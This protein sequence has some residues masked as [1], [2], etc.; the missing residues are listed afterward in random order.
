MT[1]EQEIMDF[2]YEKVFGP[3]LNSKE[4]PLSIKNGVNLTIGRMNEF[5]AKKMIRYFWSALA[6]DNAI[7][8]SK[9]LKA[10]NLPRFEDVFEE[11]RDRFNDEW[12]KK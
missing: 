10:E 7:K 11:F 12:L 2:L 5:S 3:I 1:K 4:A 9:K 8:F 6:T